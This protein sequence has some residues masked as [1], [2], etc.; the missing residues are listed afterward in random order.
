MNS[1]YVTAGAHTYRLI[2]GGFYW[3]DTRTYICRA[4]GSREIVASYH[5]TVYVDSWTGEMHVDTVDRSSL[6][7]YSAYSEA[8]SAGRA[9]RFYF[10][11]NP[12]Y[13]DT[14]GF[15]YGVETSAFGVTVGSQT[16]WARSGELAYTMVIPSGKAVSLFS[17]TGQPLKGPTTYA[18]DA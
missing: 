13:G 17:R 12:S 14:A 9:I 8:V 4:E 1:N 3:H 18:Y 5:D 11:Q 15:A 16:Q 10:K 6:D 7:S 2:K